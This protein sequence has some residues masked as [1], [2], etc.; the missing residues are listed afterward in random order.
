MTEP[1][2]IMAVPHSPRNVPTL[3]RITCPAE[4]F[5]VEEWIDLCENHRVH[6]RFYTVP[7]H[8]GVRSWL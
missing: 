7:W 4:E 8:F 6:P 1:P 2:M 5:I 3:A